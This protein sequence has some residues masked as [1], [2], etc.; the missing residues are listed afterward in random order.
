MMNTVYISLAVI[1]VVFSIIVIVATR[2]ELNSKKEINLLQGR[3]E[4][5]DNS[6]K[7]AINE[8]KITNLW[9]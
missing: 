9:S 4:N 6:I 1:F 5:S 3:L 2:I 7:D 8:L